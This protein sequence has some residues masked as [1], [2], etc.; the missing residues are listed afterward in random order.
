MPK[1][2]KPFPQTVRA[3]CLSI[4][5][6]LVAGSALAGAYDDLMAFAANNETE[7]VLELLAKGMDVNT[8]DRDGT[9]LT[10]IAARTNNHQLLDVL[11]KNR[12]S[13]LKRNRYGDDALMLA[14]FN[15]DVEAVEKLVK[16]GAWVNHDGWT[17][18]HYA[19]FQ[20]HATVVA[21]LLDHGA[22]INALAAN[23]QTALML[24][25]R[26]GHGQVVALLKQKGA[27]LGLKDP[28]GRTAQDWARESGNTGLI[29]DL[30]PPPEAPK[31]LV[32]PVTD[33]GAAPATGEV[34][35]TIQ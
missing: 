27:D 8:T 21:Y 30:T 17:P 31:P 5:I 20:G 18:L 29:K 26:H 3:L 15:G 28:Q 34:T 12:A 10:M 24:A 32:E 14:A 23:Q 13:L 9:T 11:L 2:T 7:K 19:A 16:A 6:S 33:T 22:E 4:G 35:I 1:P 25:A